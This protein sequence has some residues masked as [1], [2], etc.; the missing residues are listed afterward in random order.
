[1]A[2]GTSDLLVNAQAALDQFGAMTRMIAQLCAEYRRHL[3]AAGF[4]DEESANLIADFHLLWWES[5]LIK[6]T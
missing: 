2:D 4:D 5:Q 6:K 3:Q 1:M